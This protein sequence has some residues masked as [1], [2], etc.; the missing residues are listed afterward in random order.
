MTERPDK[1]DCGRAE[2]DTRHRQRITVVKRKRADGRT[3]VLRIAAGNERLTETLAS[4]HDDYDKAGREIFRSRNSVRIIETGGRRIAVKRF[5]K[6]SAWRR[7]IY[8]LLKSKA[9][10]ALEYSIV[11]NERG[12]KTP[13]GIA[14]V[15]IYSRGL[16]EEA[17]LVTEVSDGKQAFEALVKAEKWDERLADTVAD[18]V[19][20]M[21][22]RGIMHLD[23]NMKNFMFTTKDDGEYEVETIDIN[24]TR[25]TAGT[26]RRRP[27]VKNLA[28]LT[29]RRDLLERMTR[30]YASTMGIDGKRL[31]TEV[32][33]AVKAI[34]RNRGIRHALK[35]CIKSLAG[36]RSGALA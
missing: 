12:I 22:R 31:W 27:V 36:K 29:H 11:Y 28:R 9:R 6:L 14:S 17:Y 32:S 3:I 21:H 24:R 7:P 16:I 10:K 15:E 30:R 5:R 1:R 13:A 35:R 26:P 19:A 20:A 34:E 8:T 2:A 25:L 4:L 18:M 33:K 23:P